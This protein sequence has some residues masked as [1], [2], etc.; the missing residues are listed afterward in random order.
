MSRLFVGLDVST[1]SLSAVIID[2]DTRT[3]VY[4]TSIG[5]D[6]ALPRYGTHNGVLP[7][8]DPKVV[9]APP[10]MWAEAL[11]IL[12]EKMRRDGVKLGEVLAISGSGQQHGSVYANE[13]AAKVLAGY[14]AYRPSLCQQ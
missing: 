5:F 12:F 6:S 4:E 14:R 1:Q 13:K 7:N 10:L 8:P 3:V 2:L 9:H 11:D